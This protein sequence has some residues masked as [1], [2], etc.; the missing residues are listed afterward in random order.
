MKYTHIK[1]IADIIIASVSLLIL[2]PV[3]ISIT[4]ILAFANGGNPFFFQ[5]RV[6]KYEK[7]FRIIKFRTMNNKRDSDGNL[8]SDE[9]RLTSVGKF[10]R[11]TSLDEIPQLFNV[12][13]GDMALIGPRPL[14][15][16]YIPLYNERQR[17]RHNVLPGITG[18]AQVNGRNSISWE[19]KFEHDVWYVENISFLLDLKI[20]ILTFWKVIKRDDISSADCATRE[21]FTGNK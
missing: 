2:S 7:Q 19:N 8:L 10:I 13:T 20:L 15:V 17:K 1:T 9:E 16:S 3:I 4:I 12:A 18:W 14:L 21:P 11:S 6:G 5:T